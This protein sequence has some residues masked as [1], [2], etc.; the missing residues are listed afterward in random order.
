MTSPLADIIRAEI[1]EAGPMPVSR[2]MALALGHPKHGYYITRDPLGTDFTTS[3]EISQMFGELIG[4]W[5]ADCWAK[6]GAPSPFALVELGPGRG[7]LMADALRA[8]KAVPGFAA[9]AQICLVETSPVLRR[10]QH[11]TLRP[12]LEQGGYR[13]PRWLDSTATLPDMPLIVIANEFID[14]LPIRQFIATD[15][16][17]RERCVVEFQGNLVFTAAPAP[18]PDISILPEAVH[19]APPGAIAEICPAGTAITAD[20]ARRLK[21]RGGA[22]L[23]IDYGYGR[24]QPGDTLQAMRDGAY[25]PVLEA[26][27]TA[28][29]TAHVDFEALATS[30][31]PAAAIH[32]PATQG[33]FLLAL[34]IAQRAAM[35]AQHA[36]PDQ[37]EAIEAALTRLT[38]ADA[39]GTLF[40]VMAVTSHGLTPAGL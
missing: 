38:H 7:T 39:M 19:A 27:G 23:F 13:Q 36:T 11:E 3:P 25:V 2:F 40:K 22:A 16:G 35:L 29:I 33:Q 30:A 8:T 15:D 14:A 20:I 5:A 28:D 34:G 17:W 10:T 18:L 12:I 21:A 37:A 31:T 6:L 1:R 26:P 24:S 4:A 9:A 32:G